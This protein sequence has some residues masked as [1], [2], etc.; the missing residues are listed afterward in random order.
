M[1][2]NQFVKEYIGCSAGAFLTLVGYV[3]GSLKA[4]ILEFSEIELYCAHIVK[5]EDVE[6][7]SN[8]QL[9]ASFSTWMKIY[10]DDSLTRTYEAEK[11]NV[12]RDGYKLNLRHCTLQWRIIHRLRRMR[13]YRRNVAL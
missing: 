2:S 4:F 11:I 3:E 1:Y 6:I 8:Y 12:Y 13:V 10:D 9:C 7:D 5:G